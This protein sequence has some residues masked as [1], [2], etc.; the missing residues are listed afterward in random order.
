MGWFESNGVSWE[1]DYYNGLVKRT[2]NTF[3]NIVPDGPFSA[4]VFGL[5]CKNGILNVA[6]G[7]VNDTWS[8][9]FNYDGFFTFKNGSWQNTN[10]FTNGVINNI[11]DF[12]CTATVPSTGK[13]YFGS[14]YSGLVERD[15]NTGNLTLYNKYSSVGLLQ[16]VTGDSSRT[17]ISSLCADSSNNLWIGNTG[18]PAIIKVIKPDG[19]WRKFSTPPSVPVI[20]DAPKKLLL[21]SKDSYG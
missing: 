13:T 14:F 9:Q 8:N 21:I 15:D 6:P 18:A 11:N 16:G 7:S 5:D 20:F 19:T 3:E 1:P 2:G 17:K 10:Q 12:L 4:S